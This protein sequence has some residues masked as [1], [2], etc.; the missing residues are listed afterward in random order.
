MSKTLKVSLFRLFVR[1]VIAPIIRF[2]AY[3]GEGT[4][5]CLK[6]KCLPMPINYYSPIPDIEALKRRMVWENR[7]PMHGRD[8]RPEDQLQLLAEIGRA[9]G[10]ECDW[11]VK[12]PKGKGSFYSANG[13]F[14]YG[15]AATLHCMIPYFKTRRIIEVGSGF[16]S[17]VI[18]E[19]LKMNGEPF[20]HTVIDPF[21][22]EFV[23]SLPVFLIRNQ[24]EVIAPSTF[25]QLQE[26]DILFIDSSH[27]V[28]T[29][30]DV[31]FLILDI[32]P[33]ITPGVLIHFHD[34]C[35]PYGYPEV[36]HTNPRSRVFWTEAYLLQALLAFNKSFKVLLAMNF[37]MQDCLEYFRNAFL[38][39]NEE[40]ERMKSGSFWIR[41]VNPLD[42]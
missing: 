13:R 22:H 35:L 15:R 26:N 36:Y 37:I 20:S 18:S 3:M 27:S 4:E 9:C 10:K 24:V 2:M 32:L 5:S 21:P 8:F 33:T 28:K 23:N 29:G 34:V 14:S 7:S 42:P 6:L 17:L 12:E 38:L 11:P 40:R 39:A 16:S 41:K 31:N 30:S 25:E 19:A 1:L